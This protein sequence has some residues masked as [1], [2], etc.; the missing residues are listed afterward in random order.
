MF[1]KSSLYLLILCVALSAFL[2]TAHS[3]SSAG[4]APNSY[5]VTGP[6][7]EVTDTMIAVQKG[8]DRWE[9]GRD[10]NTKVNGGDLKAGETVTIHYTMT[11]ATVDVKAATSAAKTKKP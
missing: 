7:L 1:R 2:W 11:A 5:Q 10:G 3:A 9:L 6:V 8:K 4:A